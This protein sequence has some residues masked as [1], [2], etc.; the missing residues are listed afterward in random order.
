MIDKL[1]LHIQYECHKQGVQIPWDSIV[2]RLNP[3]SS[4]PSAIQML[5][6]LRDVLVTE[7]HMI[8][9][10]LGK[11]TSP[12]DPTLRGYIRDMDSPY[13][14]TTKAV[15]W[16]DDVTDRKESLVVP[17]L[18]RGSGKYRKVPKNELVPVPKED[19]KPGQ[20]RNRKPAEVDEW[21]AEQRSLKE[22]A[23]KGKA[24]ER[25]AKRAANGG[26]GATGSGRS[27]RAKKVI[28]DESESEIDPADLNSDEDYNPNV[29]KKT[30]SRGKRVVIGKPTS[31]DPFTSP[32]PRSRKRSAKVALNYNTGDD[33]EDEERDTPNSL[34][35][36]LRVP[37]RELQRFEPGESGK[38]P[39]NAAHF[40]PGP[41]K[42]LF[43]DEIMKA[44]LQTEV[45][46]GDVVHSVVYLGTEMH[47]TMPQFMKA[48]AEDTDPRLNGTGFGGDV[49]LMWKRC[50]ANP[51]AIQHLRQD[52]LDLLRSS[53]IPEIVRILEGLPKDAMEV[54][55]DDQH[56]VEQGD[57]DVDATENEEAP[58][59]VND[60]GYAFDNSVHGSSSQQ[61]SQSFTV[62]KF[63]T[64]SSS[65]TDN[66]R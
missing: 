60:P 9:P 30:T 41:A 31:P 53:Q 22:S 59:D 26:S 37:S 33:E 3:G 55:G 7:G 64:A 57:Y 65:P 24:E 5:N 34:I 49:D 36:K 66:L 19:L 16:T 46:G 2:H 56:E 28:K 58:F 29:K 17:G 27:T 42:I 61:F 14:T 40:N 47:G 8:P 6:K 13:P 43:K 51:L 63:P 48:V 25:E 52:E 4:G 54:D 32:T 18:V 39:K 15:R 11:A 44:L 12:V 23:K 35:V 20:R 38:K 21:A 45:A 1:V 50:Q 62:S 10:V